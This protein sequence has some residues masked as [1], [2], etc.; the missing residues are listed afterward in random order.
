LKNALGSLGSLFNDWESA[1]QLSIMMMTETRGFEK[2]RH[3]ASFLAMLDENIER[4]MAAH[5]IIT[6]RL[7][8]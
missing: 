7:P 6:L 2:A 3:I 8:G 5:Q 1:L 4:N